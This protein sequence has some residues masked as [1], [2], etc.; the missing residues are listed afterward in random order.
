MRK[1]VSPR[2]WIYA[3]MYEV[4]HMG[5]KKECKKVFHRHCFSFV[6]RNKKK[7]KLEIEEYIVYWLENYMTYMLSIFESHKLFGICLYYSFEI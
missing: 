7:T 3:L 4:S 1:K 5:L 6:A 2:S